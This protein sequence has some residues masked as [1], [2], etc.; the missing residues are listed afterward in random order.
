MRNRSLVLTCLTG[1]CGFWGLYGFITWA[2]ALMIKGHSVTPATAGL[3][4]SVFAVTA[5]AVKPAVGYVTDRF[6]EAPAEHPRSR[7]SRCSAARWCASVSSATRTRSSGS[8]R[9]WGRRPTAGPRW[10]SP[11]CPGWYRPR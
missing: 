10:S 8:P 3:V 9:C 2:N 11:W 5:I 4:V 1:F 6:F 7:S